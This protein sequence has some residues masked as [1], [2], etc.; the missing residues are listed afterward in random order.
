MICLLQFNVGMKSFMFSQLIFVNSS[1]AM[2]GYH[3]FAFSLQS[4]CDSNLHFIYEST[5]SHQSCTFS[6]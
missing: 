3:D 2:S 6:F 4:L 1:M 5:D